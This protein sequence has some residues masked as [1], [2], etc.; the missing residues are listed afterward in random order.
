MSDQ[1][2]IEW[3]DATWNP[4]TGCQKISPGCKNCYAA[5]LAVKGPF[6]AGPTFTRTK[7]TPGP[8]T[9]LGPGK[10]TLTKSD[11]PCVGENQLK[12]QAY[13]G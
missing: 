12:H 1:T 2:S 10:A 3:T 9:P 6:R 11:E 8:V 7:P 4:V 13:C 5:R